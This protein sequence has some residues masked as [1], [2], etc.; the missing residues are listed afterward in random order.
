MAIMA[1]AII[2]VMAAVMTGMRAVT[3]AMMGTAVMIKLIATA[4]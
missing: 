2:M 4:I 3:T 1:T